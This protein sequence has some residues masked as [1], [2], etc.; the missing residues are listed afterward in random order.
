MSTGS[1]HVVRLLRP[2]PKSMPQS[3]RSQ[4]L[5]S[6][7]KPV[8]IVPT[9]RQRPTAIERPQPAKAIRMGADRDIL[10]VEDVARLLHCTVDTARRIPRDQLPAYPG[11]G[12][13]RLYLR[14]DL[15][16]YIRRS[17]SISPNADVLM[18]RI[19]GEVVASPAGDGRERSARRSR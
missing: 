3:A 18:R 6:R 5:L 8:R 10:V 13:H 4:T 7:P 12:R 9:P 2:I 11:P 14:E 17:A 19:A 15:V 16:A 1:A